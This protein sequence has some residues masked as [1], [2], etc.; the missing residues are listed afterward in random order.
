MK[1]KKQ[2]RFPEG[3]DEA[4]VREVLDYYENQTEEEAIAEAEAAFES[5]TDTLMTVPNDLVPAVRELIA[6]RRLAS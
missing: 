6:K 4:R 3:W 2:T 5:R 1:E